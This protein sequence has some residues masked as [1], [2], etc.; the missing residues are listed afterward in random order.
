MAFF[1]DTESFGLNDM[2]SCLS[3][4]INVEVQT[5]ITQMILPTSVVHNISSYF[6]LWNPIFQDHRLWCTGLNFKG[7]GPILG[8]WLEQPWSLHLISNEF[9]F[10][11]Y[12]IY[13]KYI[14]T[15]WTIQLHCSSMVPCYK[16]KYINI[17][18]TYIHIHEYKSYI[19]H[20]YLDKT[21]ISSR[22]IWL[23]RSSCKQNW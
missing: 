21:E 3:P 23:Y 18:N 5:T 4:A 12:F 10:I 13:F 7:L 11:L 15:G 8:R 6:S 22:W 20:Q 9:L 2:C 1:L 16:V 14:H 19:K 17:R